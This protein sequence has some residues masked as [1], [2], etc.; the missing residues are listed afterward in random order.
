MGKPLHPTVQEFKSFVKKH[1][2]LIMEVR[3]G[4]YSWQEIYEDWY[5][6]GEKDEKWKD[7]KEKDE[8]DTESNKDDFIGKIF[9]T[10]KNAN[11]DDIQQQIS[12]VGEAITTIQAVIH[13]FK[14]E[15]NTTTQQPQQRHPHPFAF[16]KD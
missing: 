11:M 3:K 16:R 14:G 7:Y 13:Q 6:L 8:K 1:P 5:L 4:T 10:F 2:K 9:S 12:N 15:K